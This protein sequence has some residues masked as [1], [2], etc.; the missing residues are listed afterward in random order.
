MY[1]SGDSLL[2]GPGTNSPFRRSPQPYSPL[3]DSIPLGYNVVL[4]I[5]FVEGLG[6][7]V[8]GAPQVIGGLELFALMVER[9]P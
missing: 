6:P 4:V 2:A 3:S 8:T 1:V 9:R 7:S 5:V